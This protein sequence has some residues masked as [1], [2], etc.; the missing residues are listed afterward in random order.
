MVGR[1]LSFPCSEKESA[2]LWF[3][4]APGAKEVR[5]EDALL[6]KRSSTGRLRRL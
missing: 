3:R 2:W 6:K 1:K 4:P 5:A